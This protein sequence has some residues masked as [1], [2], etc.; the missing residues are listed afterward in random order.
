MKEIIAIAGPPASGKTRSVQEWVNKGYTR[1]NRDEIGGRLDLNGQLYG[2]L[3]QKAAEGVEKFV[4]DNVYVNKISR[5]ALVEVAKEVG[6]PVHLVWLDTT[7][8]QAQ[9]FAALREIRR[10]GRLIGASEYSS[11]HKIDPNTFPPVVQFSYWK[12]KEDPSPDEGFASITHVKT[13]VDMGPGYNNRAI[14]LDYDGTLRVTKSGKKYPIDPEDVVL[15]DGRRDFL[16]AKQKE[17]FLLLGASNQSGV[18]QE[19]NSPLYATEEQVRACFDRTNA[20]LGLDI[21]YIYAPEAAGVPQSYR[22]K[23]MP[24][25][26]VYFIEKYH[27]DP[28]QCIYVGDRP[29]DKG[30]AKRCGF[31]FAW[32][33]EFFR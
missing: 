9:F 21:D 32:A 23:P 14:L 1:L 2:T 13:I 27:L 18:A 33:E 26:G 3:R 29:E 20:L 28:K 7:P 31:Q 16:H 17:G 19:P 30:F 25:M 11:V 24:G 15:L 6:I 5:A 8:E 4:L 10:H 22:R 12:K